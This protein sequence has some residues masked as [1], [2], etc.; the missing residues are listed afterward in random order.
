MKQQLT[1]RT[2]SAAL[3]TAIAMPWV[4]RY[5]LAASAPI[6]LGVAATS[7]AAIGA[8]DHGDHI[9][10]TAIAVD[11]I[12]K[13]GGILGRELKQQI[14]DFDPLS[15]ESSK[16][17]VAVCIDSKVDAISNP[18][19]LPPLPA[20]EASSQYKCPFL[21]GSANRVSSE[22]VKADPAKFGHVFM[23]T[24]AETNYGWT[25]PTWLEHEEKR[26]VW[27]PKNRKIH[28][29]QEQIAYT[30]TIS[31]CAQDAIKKQGK[32]EIAKITD[33][34]YPVQDW[35]TVIRDL[36]RTDAGVIM[37]DHWVASELAGF[38][39]EFAADPVPNSLVYLQYGPSQPEFI[40][41]T[42]AIGNGFCWS[43]VTG[44]YADKIGSEFREK[45]K[46]RFS[47]VMGLAYT[48]I[49]YDIP[50]MLKRAWE[51]VGDPRKFT[52]VNDFIRTNP[53]RGVCGYYDMNNPYQEARHFPNVGF[54]DLQADSL[55]KG[56]SQLYLQIQDREHKIIY[57]NDVAEGSLKPAPWWK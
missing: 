13:A 26:G 57:P 6:V 29:V 31:K 10:G 42:G 16:Q 55:E 47:G 52:E 41:L 4:S 22:A 54:D 34:Q 53:M 7:T 39:K 1:R 48:G 2:V 15:P 18:F 14:I 56:Q 50:F 24:S 23:V 11:E 43:T 35:A 17:A 28:I 27:K 25:F 38:A 36:R 32:F 49:G 30:Q 33:I 51:A 3:G 8:A 20:M 9:N 40:T 21:H 12:N 46:K 45:Y 44:V 5:G 37:M 19:M